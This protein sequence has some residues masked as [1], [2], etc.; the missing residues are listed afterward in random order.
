VVAANVQQVLIVAALHDPPFRVGLVDR[1][2][3]AALGADL[4]PL[5]AINKCDTPEALAE[6]EKLARVYERV[7]VGVVMTSARE[8][9][10][11]DDLAARVR[12]R[13]TIVTGHS[14]VGK[15]SLL[16]R[17]I[18]DAVI[19]TG[20]VNKKTGRGR[21]TTT[22][23]TLLRLPNDPDGWIIDSPGIREFGLWD[24]GASDVAAFYP[25]LEP[26]LGTCRFNNCSHTHEPS[27]AVTGAVERGEIHPLRY[28]SYLRIIESLT[29]SR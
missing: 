21:H 27:C 5:L 22:S 29:A 14:G 13:T 23:I 25:E 10:G 3:I 16:S 9:Y 17:L 12:G 28:E 2:L 6:A 20:D 1:F 15:S 19:R 18:P 7:S 24:I 4:E 26:L 11:L 8:G